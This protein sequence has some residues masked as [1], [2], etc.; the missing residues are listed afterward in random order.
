MSTK[1][2]VSPEETPASPETGEAP[3]ER[4]AYAPPVLSRFGDVRSV[5]LGGSRGGGDSGN[6][7]SENPFGS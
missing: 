2:E 1:N 4:R 3:I 6:V 7:F 5:T